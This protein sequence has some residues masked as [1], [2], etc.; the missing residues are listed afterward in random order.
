VIK[1]IWHDPVW[2]KVISAVILG[3]LAWAGTHFG[4]WS[5]VAHF[6]SL[7]WSAAVP[8]WLLLLIV[9]PL[10][11]ITVVF[12]RRRTRASETLRIVQDI[13][14]SFWGPGRRGE[15]PV[16]Q[17]SLDGHVTDISGKQ[18]RI[19]R[20]EI[21]K[22]LTHADMV[23]LSNHHD[24]RRPQVLSPN[25][26]A[27][28]R[29]S[30]FVEPVV[31]KPGKNWR[32]TVIFIDQYGNRHKIKNCVFQSLPSAKPTTPAEPEEYPYEINDRIE[33]EVVSVLKA[34]LSRYGV[35]GRICGGLGS[36]H[37]VYRGHALTGVGGDSWTSN[38]PLNQVIAS[39]PVAASLKSD[40]LDALV[41]FHKGL[42][43]DEERNRFVQALL[44]RLDANRGY[45]GISYFIV[46]VLWMVGS[47]ADALQKAKHS[48][49][50]GE[51]R[52]FGLSNVLMF[53][54]GLLKYRY[55]DFTNDMLDDIERMTHGLSEHV[56]LIP[57]KL[58]AIRAS[59][60]PAAAA[61]KPPQPA[62]KILK[63]D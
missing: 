33:K 46:A 53:L 7:L 59:R 47:L 9:L 23:L 35:C 43:S 42:Q 57:A 19:V 13:R 29:V 63:Q 44:D 34:E 36:I 60:L 21:P 6:W 52:V 11:T 38:S 45:L 2:S 28:I 1:R 24:A 40:N 56:F 22:P 3:M 49:P 26:C 30:F 39:D 16:M 48:L 14:S 50:V 37:I 25:E 62:V 4:W 32:S 51:T 15:T 55:P 58:A 54:N 20:A 31:A 8:L 41:G 10:L 61:I 18:N 5:A 17:V 12:Y 27:E